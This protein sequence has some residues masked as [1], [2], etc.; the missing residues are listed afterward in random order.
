MATVLNRNTLTLLSSVHTPNYPTEDWIVNPDLSAVVS[1]PT[2]YW[3][4]VGDV[5]SE[6]IQVEKDVVDAAGLDALKASRYVEIDTKTASLIRVGFEYPASSGTIVS[7]S[8]EG[9]N[10]IHG[11]YSARNLSGF[12]YP[13]VWL[14]K[15]DTTSISLTDA[16]EI[17]AFFFAA[18]ETIRDHKDY[19]STLKEQVRAAVDKAA[20]DAIVDTR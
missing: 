13:V 12:V 10:S 5:V 3:K 15:D 16:S 1:V 19:G 18:V 2:R 14:S 11:A 8:L 7:L 20:V 9:Q 17:E 4:I 6:M